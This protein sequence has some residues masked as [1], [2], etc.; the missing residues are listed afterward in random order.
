MKQPFHVWY[1]SH[2]LTIST[3]PR[4]IELACHKKKKCPRA[5]HSCSSCP[6]NIC[7]SLGANLVSISFG[8]FKKRLPNT[9]TRTQ[10]LRT[11]RTKPLWWILNCLSGVCLSFFTRALQTVSCAWM[12][13]LSNVAPWCDRSMVIIHS[14]ARGTTAHEVK[15]ECL[16][17]DRASVSN[18]FP[19]Y[20]DI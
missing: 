16:H 15:I 10:P 17:L 4:C 6:E 19:H 2:A 1:R 7:W 18:F 8:N 5:S 14:G 11:T 3:W 20:G 9:H 12:W 13:L